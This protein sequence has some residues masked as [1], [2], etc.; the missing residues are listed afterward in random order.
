MHFDDMNTGQL[1]DN[2]VVVIR[3]NGPVAYPGAPEVV[4]MHAPARLLRMGIRDVPCIGDGHQS[5]T[6]TS[7]SILHTSPEQRLAVI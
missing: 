7:P 6:S 3:G 5:G 4:N 1:G 2:I